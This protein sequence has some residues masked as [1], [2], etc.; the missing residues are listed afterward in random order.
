MFGLLGRVAECPAPA[1]LGFRP[2]SERVLRR[3]A[4]REPV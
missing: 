4:T 2:G 1:W 3:V